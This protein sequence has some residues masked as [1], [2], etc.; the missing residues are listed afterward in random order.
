MIFI[1]GRE[2][3]LLI[4]GPWGCGKT[5]QIYN[6]F[7]KNYKDKKQ[8][9]VYISLFGKDSLD[10][11]N[12]EIYISLNYKKTKNIM[13]FVKTINLISKAISTVPKGQHASGGLDALSS[14]LTNFSNKPIETGCIVILDDIERLCEKLSYKDLFGYINSLLNNRTRIVGVC[15][16][17]NIKEKTEF[18]DFKEKIFDRIITI[19]EIDSEVIKGIFSKHEINNIESIT[20]IFENNYRNAHKTEILYNEVIEF[21]NK[22]NQNIFKYYESISLIRHCNKV[23]KTCFLDNKTPLFDNETS[24]QK[25]S[26][27]IDKEKYNESIA[28]GIYTE[29]KKEREN[30]SRKE[31]Y[32]EELIYVLIEAFLYRRFSRLETLISPPP[33]DYEDIRFLTKDY[34][35]LSEKNRLLYVKSLEIHIKS[36]EL[37]INNYS[38][39]KI[40]N[41]SK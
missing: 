9:I 27:D 13:R 2:K 12:T 33:N 4:D 34:F 32:D 28:S 10:E 35:F 5:Y 37:N 3:S 26:F 19:D 16:S 15:S 38:E 40:F 17:G 39:L 24:I 11:I 30:E 21:S 8:K 23:I 1:I 36:K 7:H 20:G 29:I 6:V 31:Y 25:I 18:Q 41:L 14:V 22:I